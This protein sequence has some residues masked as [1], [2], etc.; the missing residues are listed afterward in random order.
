[1]ILL[2]E[3]G[4]Q[5]SLRNHSHVNLIP[6]LDDVRSRHDQHNR[7]PGYPTGHFPDTRYPRYPD[8]VHS[9]GGS[10]RVPGELRRPVQLSPLQSHQTR[11]GV[12]DL[13]THPGG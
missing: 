11:S 3:I 9:G 10:G 12:S 2:F 1:M 7:D 5:L 8:S 6:K 13:R 4:Q